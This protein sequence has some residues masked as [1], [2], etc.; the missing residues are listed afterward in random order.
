MYNIDITRF[1][2]TQNRMDPTSNAK[3]IQ[4]L[5]RGH[6]QGELHHKNVPHCSWVKFVDQPEVTVP[7]NKDLAGPHV[8]QDAGIKQIYQN[9]DYSCHQVISLWVFL[10]ETIANLQKLS[11][12]I[13]NV[14][15]LWVLLQETTVNLQKTFHNSKRV[16][17]TY[18][19]LKKKM[20]ISYFSCGQGCNL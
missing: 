16:Y 9:R 12:T 7:W 13:L 2:A 5:L 15:P 14:I 19:P 6:I 17:Q 1:L 10:Q 20:Q 11:S 3:Q 8:S 4:Q 18:Y